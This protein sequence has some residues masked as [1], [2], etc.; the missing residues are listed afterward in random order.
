MTDEQWKA[1]EENDRSYDGK[2]YYGLT[3]TMNVCRPSCPA[4]ACK[5]ENVVIFQSLED[6]LKSGYTPCK[7]CCPEKENWKGPRQELADKAQKYIEEHYTEKFSLTALAEEL[8]SNPSYLLRTFRDMTGY[9]T[10]E[11]HNMVRCKKACELLKE[12]DHKL[13]YISDMVG[14]NSP[15]HFT[16]VFEKIYGISPV[17]YRRQEKE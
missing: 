10:L 17:E 12:T 3:S 7:R 16:R 11:Y 14:Y 4:R 1:I 8:F 6:A 13:A 9:T 5:R 2:F 15:S